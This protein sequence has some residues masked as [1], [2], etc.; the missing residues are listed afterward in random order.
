MAV[1][2]FATCKKPRHRSG[3]DGDM[4]TDPHVAIPKPAGDNS[5]PLTGIGI[6]NPKEIVRQ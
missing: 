3:A 6:L 5:E 1:R 2:F 4:L